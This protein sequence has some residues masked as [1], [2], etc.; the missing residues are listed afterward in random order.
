MPIGIE[1][2]SLILI[3]LLDSLSKGQNKKIKTILK[4]IIDKKNDLETDE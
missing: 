1:S 3:L 4:T 2:I